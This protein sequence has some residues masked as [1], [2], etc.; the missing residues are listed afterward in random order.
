MFRPAIRAANRPRE[1]LGTRP[2]LDD[3]AAGAD[4]DPVGQQQRVEDVVGDQDDGPV[5]EHPAQCLA[6]GGGDRD[7]QRRHRLVEEQQPGLGGQRAGHRDPLRLASGDLA[8]VPLGEVGGIDLGE[9]A[10][11]RL[12][13]GS[14]S[15][16]EAAR[17][18]R[19]VVG[20]AQVREQQGVLREQ[21]DPAG[22]RRD[23]GALAG[24]LATAED[25]P[26]A[27]GPQGAGGHGQEGGLPGAVGAQQRDGLALGDLDR[28]VHVAVRHR[29][30]ELERHRALPS[31]RGR[32][33]AKP[34]TTPATTT[35]TSDIATAASGS[36]TRRL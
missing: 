10:P 8:G 34:L 4:H 27:V 24:E 21:R 12:A 25:D 33:R 7:V 19:D 17:P 13:G 2:V 30:G 14:P 9:P 3:A 26:T 1:A 22:V 32:W 28:D 36:V 18:E 35:S 20:H 11:G 31:R 29:G 23:E 15:V 16:A 6:Q 5:G